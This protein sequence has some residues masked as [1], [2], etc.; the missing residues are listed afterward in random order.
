[1]NKHTKKAI[2]LAAA[3]TSLGASLGVAPIKAE[4]AVDMFGVQSNADS[5]KKSTQGKISTQVK[6]ETQATTPVSNQSKVSNQHKW[7][8]NK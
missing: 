5:L 4:A 8:G 7:T 2:A 3:V 6:I 1:M